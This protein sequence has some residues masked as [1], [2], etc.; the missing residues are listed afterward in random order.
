LNHPL[1]NQSNLDTMRNGHLLVVA[2]AFVHTTIA[3]LSS[4]QALFLDLVNKYNRVYENA[5]TTFSRYNTFLTNYEKIEQH[6]G[7]NATW[8]M[9]WN[10]FFDLTETEFRETLRLIRAFPRNCSSLP[11]LSSDTPTSMDWREKGVI[12]GVKDQGACGSCW[13]FSA[14]GALEAANAI[15]TGTLQTF[16]EQELVDCA[17]QYGNYGCGGGLMDFAYRYIIDKGICTEDD[18]N[19]TQVDGKCRA[20]K[21]THKKGTMSKC[22]DVPDHNE[23]LIKGI[24]AKTG[25]VSIAVQAETWQFYQKGVYDAL[26]GDSLDHGV[27]IVGYGTEQEKDYWI[28]RNSWGRDWGE[29][30]YIRLVRGRN[31]CGLTEYVSY[32]VV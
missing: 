19:Y 27:V 13:A 30:G 20:D 6:N 26:C 8:T 4:K 24:I 28:V 3:A 17:T 1:L 21:C 23:E 10:Q 15:Q 9:G 31:E 18:Y 12:A 16:S 14:I 29:K 11:P 5:E 2:F 7:R 32:P 25:P 22:V